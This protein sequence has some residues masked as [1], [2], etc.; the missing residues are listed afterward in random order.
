MTIPNQLT[1]LRILLSPVF[2]VLF[3]SSNTSTKVISFFVFLIAALTDWYDG[4][5][6]RKYGY[7]TEWGKFLDPLADKVLTSCAFYAFY[8][9]GY[10]QLWMLVIIILRDIGITL[11]RSIAGWKRK[12]IKTTFSAKVKTF[13]QLSV[14]FYFL[15]FYIFSEVDWIRN[16]FGETLYYLIHPNFIYLLMMIVTILTLYTGIM[17]L[18]DNWKTIRELYADPSR[19]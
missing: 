2:L 14:V 19:I 13:F 3:F 8:V 17:Y 18:V 6:A 1:V 11:L 4:M 15:F 16:N 9:I 10:L 7:I 12:P 5:I